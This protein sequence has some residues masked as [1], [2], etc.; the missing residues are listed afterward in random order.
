MAQYHN[1]PYIS[2]VF[3]PEIARQ[4]Q[5]KGEMVVYG[6]AFNLPIL[7]KAHVSTAHIVVISIG[8]L[9]VLK[10]IIDKVRLLNKHASIVVRTRHIEDIEELYK[11][12]ATQVIPEEF[13]TAINLFE[14][15]MA[16]FLLPRKEI[17]MAI[18]RIRNDHYGIFLE[19]NGNTRFNISKDIPDIEIIALEV[20]K[21]APIEGKTLAD[22][23][24][25]QKFGITL[26][27]LKRDNKV[28]DHPRPSLAFC[29][30]DIAYV[31]GKS[32]QISKAGELFAPEVALKP[33]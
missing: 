6:D 19:E 33:N 18:D 5:E 25:R 22:S 29:E 8:K 32:E 14:R 24:L 9:E 28:Y 20:M 26:V 15:V 2:I 4:R 23:E 21:G 12:G 31:L 13:E 27:A 10:T 7:E 3:D 16:N 17:D 11:I 30:G 1:L